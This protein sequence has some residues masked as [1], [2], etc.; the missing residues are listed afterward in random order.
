M[1]KGSEENDH[2]VTGKKQKNTIYE[3]NLTLQTDEDFK[4]ISISN[5]HHLPSEENLDNDSADQKIQFESSN[6]YEMREI[7]AKN[8]KRYTH[9]TDHETVLG[10]TS[11]PS[12][13][14]FISAQTLNSRDSNANDNRTEDYSN[15]G[16]NH[17]TD[18]QNEEQARNREEMLGN[19]PQPP[20]GLHFNPDHGR[21]W[22]VLVASF[23][24]NVIADGVYFSIGVFYV[25][26]LEEFEEGKTKTSVLGLVQQISYDAIGNIHTC[27]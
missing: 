13:S 5:K 18:H 23:I 20:C 6:E 17:I 14:I 9:Q 8:D 19:S 26:L 21:A 2:D 27:M 15:G 25:E 1:M 12:E 3:D 11:D 7:S 22:V 24:I 16:L 10:K 4:K